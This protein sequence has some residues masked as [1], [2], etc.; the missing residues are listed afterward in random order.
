MIT[1]KSIRNKLILIFFLEKMI[2]T[3]LLVVLKQKL[4]NIWRILSCFIIYFHPKV[5]GSSRITNKYRYLTG[6]ILFL[7]HDI[8][9][10]TD[11]GSATVCPC[12]TRKGISK[13]MGSSPNLTII[14]LRKKNLKNEGI[15]NEL[16]EIITENY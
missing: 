9:W 6:F 15:M 12:V 16:D 13:S 14:Y 8:S 7:I 1:N 11:I 5:A 3:G 10:L 4:N 2:W